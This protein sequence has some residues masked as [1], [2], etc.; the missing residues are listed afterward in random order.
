MP[1]KY[2]HYSTTFRRLKIWQNEG[3]WSKILGSLINYSKLSLEKVSVD[4]TT[5]EARKS[6]NHRLRWE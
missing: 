5:V 2:G 1:I 3:V 4:S 6:C